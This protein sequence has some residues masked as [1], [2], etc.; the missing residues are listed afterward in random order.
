VRPRRGS[1]TRRVNEPHRSSN[2]QDFNHQA[3]YIH[4]NP[5]NMVG[6]AVLPIYRIQ[7]FINTYG[8]GFT[9]WIGAAGWMRLWLGN[10]AN[11]AVRAL[12]HPTVIQAQASPILFLIFSTS[13]IFVYAGIY[14]RDFF[15]VSIWIAEKRVVKNHMVV[16]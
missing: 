12:P 2:Q 8:T 16:K 5:V 4:W 14:I 1:R 9:R 7:V 6:C 11:D 3:D 13:C 15:S 10:D